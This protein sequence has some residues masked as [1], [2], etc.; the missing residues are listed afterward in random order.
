MK[1][2]ALL[3]PAAGRGRGIARIQRFRQLLDAAFDEVRYEETTAPGQEGDRIDAALAA[4]CDVVIALGGDG[5]WSIVANHLLQSGRA[6]IPLGLLPAGT[7]NDFGKSL[8]ITFDR[9]AQVVAAIAS[10]QRRRV[11]V[12]RVNGRF[13]LNVV[14]LGF[15]IAVIHDAEQLSWLKGDLLYQFCALRQLFRYRGLPFSVGSEGER[16][17]RLGHLML[18]IANGQYFGGSFHIA[19]EGSLSDGRLDAVSIYD[20]GP[21]RRAQLFQ[22]VGRGTHVGDPRVRVLS[23]A[24]IRVEFDGPLEYEVDGEV[25]CAD[26]D[27]LDIECR[28][29]ALSVFVPEGAEGES[30]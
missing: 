5:T 8:G 3:N 27:A 17:N 2:V 26:T 28:P 15:D 29:A 25:L 20:A 4:G 10:G 14:G 13:F 18:V 23:A 12:G 22:K 24:S 11:D 7:G 19:P 1:P 16:G 9:S 30:S 21:L 6:D